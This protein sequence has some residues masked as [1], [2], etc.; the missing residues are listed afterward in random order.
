MRPPGTCEQVNKLKLLNIELAVEG[1]DYRVKKSFN[2]KS[3]DASH[4]VG[5]V[6]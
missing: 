6:Y 4:F 5:K 1:G 2:E 3:P